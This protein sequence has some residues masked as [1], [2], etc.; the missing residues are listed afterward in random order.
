MGSGNL[1]TAYRP[2]SKQDESWLGPVVRPRLLD[3][4]VPVRDETSLSL[5]VGGFGDSGTAHTGSAEYGTAMSQTVELYQ[6]ER[7]LLRTDSSYVYAYDLAPETLPYRLVTDTTGDT[8]LNP[9]STATHT[10]W[11]FTSG[12]TATGT[13]P[14]AQL[15]YAA[16]LDASGRAQRTADLTITPTL[17]GI[18][19]GNDA[20]TGAGLEVSYDDGAT[21]HRQDLKEKKGTWQASLRA[22]TGAAFVSIRVTAAQ[23]TGNSV[24]QTVIRAFGLT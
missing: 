8:G 18:A 3:G 4:D 22:P 10:E 12:A 6:G 11:R 7:Q 15:D 2:G 17:P 23:R 14:L 19:T 20:V 24:T 21:W 16:D 5:H 13:V 1:P 9:Y